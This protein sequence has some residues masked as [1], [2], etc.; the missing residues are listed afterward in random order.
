MPKL[1]AIRQA[2]QSGAP[3]AELDKPRIWY[4]C[5]NCI[6]GTHYLCEEVDPEKKK[7]QCKCPC[8]LGSELNTDVAPKIDWNDLFKEQI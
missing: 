5:L 8:K 1:A 4:Q 7:C 2:L 3:T 6:K